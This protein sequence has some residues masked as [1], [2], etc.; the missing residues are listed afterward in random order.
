MFTWLRL[1]RR[2]NAI[3][4][5]HQPFAKDCETLYTLTVQTTMGTSG[6]T[7]SCEY[8]DP[9]LSKPIAYWPSLIVSLA[10]ESSLPTALVDTAEPTKWDGYRLQVSRAYNWNAAGSY[11]STHLPNGY[12]RPRGSSLWQS[13]AIARPFAHCCTRGIFRKAYQSYGA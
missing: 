11:L 2:R 9:R 6:A 12:T 4:K 3:F 8:P 5:D 13:E 10:S 7:H 1:S